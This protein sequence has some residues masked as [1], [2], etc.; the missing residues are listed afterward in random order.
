[1]KRK[2]YKRFRAHLEVGTLKGRFRWSTKLSISSVKLKI[3][4]WIRKAN[5]KRAIAVK[6]ACQFSK[7]TRKIIHFA[8]NPSWINLILDL[9]SFRRANR[10]P[11]KSSVYLDHKIKVHL[12]TT[13][14]WTPQ[15]ILKRVKARN[16]LTK[17]IAIRARMKNLFFSLIRHSHGYPRK[18]QENL[19]I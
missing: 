18:S 6:V 4:S 10:P 15:L 19:K 14:R 7:L 5:Y 2:R 12:S 8:S 16:K 17:M 9:W 13:V 1:M 3:S 11:I